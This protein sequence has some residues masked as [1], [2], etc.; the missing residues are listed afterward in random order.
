M[1]L[2]ALAVV[3]VLLGPPGSGKST[4]AQLLA[5]RYGL[6]TVATGELLRTEAARPTA[7]G[8]RIAAAQARGDLVSDEIVDRVVARR[9][10]AGGAAR[11]FVL[12]GFPR[13]VAQ[14][15]F[16]DGWLA[17]RHRPPPTVVQLEVPPA[18]LL[19]RL[20]GR[21]RSD[22]TPA[23]IAARLRAFEAELLP[24]AA[25]YAATGDYHRVRGDRP[26]EAVFH[27]LAAVLSATQP[28]SAR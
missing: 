20:S 19:A 25:H 7:L 17:A 2:S 8:R 24:I 12:D 26:P 5:A 21:G 27:D 3:V 6:V 18:V 13:T 28:R 16:L 15:R 10:A 11:G 1:G 22:D 14:A 4:Q 9:L 23:A